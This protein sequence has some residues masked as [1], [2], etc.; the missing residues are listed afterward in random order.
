MDKLLTL[1]TYIFDPLH[2]FWE[3]ERT[4]KNRGGP[5]GAHFPFGAG[6]Y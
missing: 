5:A 4:Q 2:H 1:A 6:S 3:H